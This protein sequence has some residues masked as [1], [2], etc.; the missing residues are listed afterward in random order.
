MALAGT[1]AHD[2]IELEINNQR[3]RDFA[4]TLRMECQVRRAKY[5]LSIGIASRGCCFQF[6]A[7]AIPEFKTSLEIEHH[8]G[9]SHV[10]KPL[11]ISS[12]K[13]AAATTTAPSE[14]VQ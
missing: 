5:S 11:S 3:V 12:T 13:A 9:A 2:V 14:S 6:T 8:L 4:R 10:S 7:F 1:R